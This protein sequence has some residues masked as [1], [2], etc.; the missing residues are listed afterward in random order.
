MAAISAS[1]NSVSTARFVLVVSCYAHIHTARVD[2][3][4]HVFLRNFII[5]LLNAL[6]LRVPSANITP[7]V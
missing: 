1:F 6:P 4:D 3:V 5:Q 7:Y 2:I